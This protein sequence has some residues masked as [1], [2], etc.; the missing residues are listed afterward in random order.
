MGGRWFY[1][2]S[3]DTEMK[4]RKEL[5][6]QDGSAGKT[7]FGQLAVSDSVVSYIRD[8]KEQEEETKQAALASYLINTEEPMTQD[9]AYKVYPELKELPDK[10]FE[11]YLAMM[12]GLRDMLRDGK[13][14]S[15]KDNEFIFRMLQPDFQLPIAPV[16][17]PTGTIMAEIY[18][19]DAFQ[20]LINP[21]GVRSGIFSPRRWGVQEDEEDTK[22]LL[23]LYVK[24]LILLRLYPGIR[25][26]K[27]NGEIS[28]PAAVTIQGL[29]AWMQ[30]EAG[31][32]KIARLYGFGNESFSKGD[33]SLLQ[34]KSIKTPF[35]VGFLE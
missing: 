4:I 5:I 1:P 19:S 10:Y 23:Q 28:M 35:P 29:T 12:C 14:N 2:D 8:K 6:D 31:G 9:H 25:Q 3:R 22:S 21:Q 17:D 24:T 26:M 15:K 7:P 16:W 30:D 32:K 11:E 20:N 13:I 33:Y 34:Q 27:K 18:K